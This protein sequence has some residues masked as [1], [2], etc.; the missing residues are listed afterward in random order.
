MI[1][2]NSKDNNCIFYVKYFLGCKMYIYK[3]LVVLKNF[4][5]K[6]WLM[7]VL[8]MNIATFKL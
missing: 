8:L 2:D 6:I 3:M 5:I 1:N 7:L 4:R